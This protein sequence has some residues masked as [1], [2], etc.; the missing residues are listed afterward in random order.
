MCQKLLIDTVTLLCGLVASARDRVDLQAAGYGGREG[1]R[2]GGRD[3]GREGGRQAGRE[4]WREGGGGGG[5][6]AWR[7]KCFRY[8]LLCGLVASARDRVDLQAAGYRPGGNP[9]GKWMIG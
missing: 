9:G 5:R 6:E 3:G 8:P 7:D 4:G 2:Q 1:G